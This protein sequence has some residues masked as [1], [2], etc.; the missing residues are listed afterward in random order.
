MISA[1]Q[2]RWNILYIPA[3]CRQGSA[4]F[5]LILEVLKPKLPRGFLLRR[6]HGLSYLTLSFHRH[7][8]Y[9]WMP[10]QNFG[11]EIIWCFECWIDIFFKNNRPVKRS[12]YNSTLIW[13]S[14]MYFCRTT[15]SIKLEKC[16]ST[17]PLQEGIGLIFKSYFHMSLLFGDEIN[18]L[19]FFCKIT[20]YWRI[21][22][23][24]NITFTDTKL[25][26][27]VQIFT[28]E[29]HRAIRV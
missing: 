10:S 26:S 5:N 17:L 27:N 6:F 13:K 28:K 12:S 3:A 29:Y 4:K 21:Y 9:V 2:F 1:S 23:A 8:F 25:I 19:F 14:Q 7:W 20:I 15:T 16:H 18:S 11:C 22:T 24:W